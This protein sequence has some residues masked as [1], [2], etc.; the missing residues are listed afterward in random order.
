MSDRDNPA[1]SPRTERTSGGR[2][3]P[4][5]TISK[6]GGAAGG[7][8]SAP[9]EAAFL[10]ATVE[11]CSP[12]Q[13]TEVVDVVRK[14]ALEGSAPHASLLARVLGLYKDDA[15]PPEAAEGYSIGDALM[16]DP[17][18]AE[19]IDALMTK[20]FAADGKGPVPTPRQGP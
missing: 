9:R 13:W 11:G 12:E 20:V 17:S 6:L 5:N 10:S 7:R 19:D 14:K 15:R 4:G 3:A 2:F 1:E 8:P 18:L 16:K